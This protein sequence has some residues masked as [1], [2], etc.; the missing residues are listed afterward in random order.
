PAL[1]GFIRQQA[2]AMQRL[3]QRQRLA[4]VPVVTAADPPDPASVS[5]A[6]GQATGAR[7]NEAAQLLQALADRRRETGRLQMQAAQQGAR[8]NLL[9][10]GDPLQRLGTPRY[11]AVEQV[12]L[13]GKLG[14]R[15][16]TLGTMPQETLVERLE[17]ATDQIQLVVPTASGRAQGRRFGR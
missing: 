3:R 9:E 8:E 6:L 15:R 2:P 12:T 11:P 7:T 10:A 4:R 1:S 17:A 5:V 13:G 16:V 14:H